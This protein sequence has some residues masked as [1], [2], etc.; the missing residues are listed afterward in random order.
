MFHKT[1]S[2][3]SK[4]FEFEPLSV[5]PK[6]PVS[7]IFGQGLR[8]PLW[9]S[10]KLIS[11]LFAKALKAEKDHE[12][13]STFVKS[14]YGPRAYAADADCQNIDAELPFYEQDLETV[15]NALDEERHQYL[16]GA[17]RTDSK[18]RISSTFPLS[19]HKYRVGTECPTLSY[20]LTLWGANFEIQ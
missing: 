20:M 19:S 17:Y 4:S 1:S 5:N 8:V 15:T 3:T 6:N 13:F 16:R 7:K 11:E 9:N 10:E 2:F 18:A 12:V 14:Y